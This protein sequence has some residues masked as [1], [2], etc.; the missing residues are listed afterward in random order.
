LQNNSAQFGPC[1]N[2]GSTRLCVYVK[3][4]SVII[5]RRYITSMLTY[6]V[7][8]DKKMD[9]VTTYGIHSAIITLLN[10]FDNIL[11]S[12]MADHAI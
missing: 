3:F 4:G 2:F 6:L 9:L 7:T 10:R 5:I 11:G 1:Q 8:S 12:K